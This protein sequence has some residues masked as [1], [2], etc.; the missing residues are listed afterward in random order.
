M[1]LA[2]LIFMFIGAIALL[3][4]AYSSVRYYILYPATIS[5]I[6]TYMVLIVNIVYTITGILF[7]LY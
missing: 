2:K 6:I 5:G 4:T 7:G 3:F 1:V